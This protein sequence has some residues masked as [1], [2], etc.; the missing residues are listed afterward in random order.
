M[1]TAHTLSMLGCSVLL[2]LAAP[3]AAQQQAESP[4]LDIQWNS[5]IV[6]RLLQVP[7]T[8]CQ[9]ASDPDA[10]PIERKEYGEYDEWS[11][12]LQLSMLRAMFYLAYDYYGMGLNHYFT[13]RQDLMVDY[14]RRF[15]GEKPQKTKNGG[16]LVVPGYVALQRSTDAKAQA[17]E[18]EVS[19]TPGGSSTSI[20]FRHVIVDPFDQE[21]LAEQQ[22]AF[23]LTGLSA[24][25]SNA[26]PMDFQ[27][28]PDYLP[29]FT[30]GKSGERS[31]G[32]VRMSGS[33]HP[34]NPEGHFRRNPLF[35]RTDHGHYT[36]FLVEKFPEQVNG[37]THGVLESFGQGML[38]VQGEGQME[39]GYTSPLLCAQWRL[40]QERERTGRG[41]ASDRLLQALLQ[42]AGV[43]DELPG[44]WVI[45]AR[46][47]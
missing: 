17:G 7:T 42:R 19:A 31:F 21:L 12:T 27:L 13:L 22:D 18:I 35:S 44:V 10:S 24:T 16:R 15:A 5:P 32:M 34:A 9:G 38:P 28:P 26:M 41:T 11:P 4:Y 39:T 1:K 37:K 45:P 29:S 46:E 20:H 14:T 30:L 6:L 2:A 3:A 23:Y 25:G 8:Q 33:F 43:S 47:L 36:Y 40:Q